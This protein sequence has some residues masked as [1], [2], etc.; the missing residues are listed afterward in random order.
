MGSSIQNAFA[1]HSPLP[2]HTYCPLCQGE[3]PVTCH[4]HP[5]EYIYHFDDKS[6]ETIAALLDSKQHRLNIILEEDSGH[7]SLTNGVR[8]L[9]YGVLVREDGAGPIG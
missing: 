7:G 5:T 6:Q 2:P 8:L 3:P 1:S 9:G 4:Q